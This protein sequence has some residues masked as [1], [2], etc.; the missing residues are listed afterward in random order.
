MCECQA[1][2]NNLHAKLHD[3]IMK[4]DCE[5]ITALLKIHPINN[6]I[7][8][9]KNCATFPT[10]Q[11]QVTV[12]PIHLAATYRK[13]KSLQCLLQLKADME[14]R[15]NR[16]RTALHLIIMHWPNIV[17]NW[18]EPKTKFQ[19]AMAAMQNRTESC[20]HL[21][22]QHGVQVNAS[23]ESDSQHTPMHLAV[24]HGAFPAISILAQHG[25]N[26]NAIDKYGMTPLH[27]ATGILHKEMTEKLISYGADVNSKIPHSGN[28][29][30]K[31][32]VCTASSKGGKLLGTDLGCIHVLLS[33][34]AE[35]NA[36]DQEGRAAIHDACF[37]GREEIVDLLLEHDADFNLQTKLGESP[38]FLFL[39]RRPNLK[40]TRLLGK[41]LSL[42]H[43]LR[44]STGGGLLPSGLLY[45]EHQQHKEF[46][47]TLIQEP[48]GLRDICRIKVRK[49]Y[50]H[51][52]SE[53]LK[54]ILPK[55][56]WEFV[57]SYPDYSDHFHEM[58]R[59][60]QSNTHLH[61]REL[62]QRLGNMHLS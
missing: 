20:L 37:G 40:C 8:I 46:L 2:F 41:L 58:T 31:L 15:D 55:V 56:L 39:D 44:I 1:E 9:W 13:E 36:Q 53:R 32:A 35:V 45:P 18:I 62:D 10:L 16:G 59:K 25:A 30:L 33:C 57:Y 14:A 11:T 17:T 50:G 34:G 21:L 7:T 12:L 48:P 22:C 28:T 49:M 54:E 60:Q 24:R 43:P 26:I 23:M 4:G 19:R 29:P 5:N 42:S 51:R 52:H 6:P 27:M 38:L 61:T 3:A 47:L